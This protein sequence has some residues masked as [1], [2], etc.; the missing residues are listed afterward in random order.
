VQKNG[1]TVSKTELGAFFR[2]PSHRNYRDCGDQ[3]LRAF[4]KG[5]ASR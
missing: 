3:V 5:L 2:R 4:L 1:L